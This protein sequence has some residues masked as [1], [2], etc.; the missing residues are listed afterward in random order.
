MVTV[1][2]SL[3]GHILLVRPG[4]LSSVTQ[5]TQTQAGAAPSE[6]PDPRRW[7]ILGVSLVIGFMALLDVSVVNLAVPSMQEGMH[8]SA[9]TIQWVVSGYALAFGLTLV[10]GGRIGDAFGRRRMMLIGLLGFIASSAAVGLS[11]RSDG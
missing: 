5:Q 8:A 1:I 11:P 9:G 6:E 10:A 7:R 4:N 3:M 2:G